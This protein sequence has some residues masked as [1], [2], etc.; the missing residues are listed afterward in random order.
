MGNIKNFHWHG[1]NDIN[2]RINHINKSN[3]ASIFANKRNMISVTIKIQ[4]TD[5][6][7]KTILIPSSLLLKHIYLIDHHTE[8][9]I[10]Y[11]AAGNDPFTWSY[12]D[13]PNEFTAIP[14]SSSYI[15]LKPDKKSDNSVI[16]YVYCSPSAINQVKKI[17]VLVKTP[18]YEYTT[19]HQEK[20]DAFI[21][22]TSLNEI[23]Y[24]LSDLE[25]NEVLITTH[26]E[27]DDTFF[28]NQFNTYVSLKQKDKYGKRNI[29]KLENFGG[30]LDSVHQLYHLDTGYSRYYSHFLW[31]LGEYTTVSVGNT[32]WFDLNITHPIDIE[33]RQIANA[34][35]FTVIF[36]GFDSIGK[37]QDTWYDMYIKI[38][39]QFGNNGTFD[40][41]PRNDNHQEKLKVHLA[42]H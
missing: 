24:H 2:I 21:Q 9:K 26:S 10:T 41:V 11:K 17:A 4:P 34:L 3:T 28:W 37:S 22:L 20:K 32:K 33:I 38:Y 8:E 5:I 35:C 7:G 36:M 15:V 14:G 42:D 29:I 31:S 25:S 6:Y 23:Y 13:D 1:V 39:D 16:F 19:A 12:T 27:W 40:I 30:M 18:R